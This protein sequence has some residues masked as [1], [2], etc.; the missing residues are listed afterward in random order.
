MDKVFLDKTGNNYF[1]YVKFAENIH[2]EINKIRTDPKSYAV[3]LSKLM[4]NYDH[5][6]K[7]LILGKSELEISEGY[8]ALE[9]AYQ[10]LM[11]KESSHALNFKNGLQKSAE[12]LVSLLVVNEGIENGNSYIF[13]NIDSRLNKYGVPIG[14]LHEIID[15]GSW[16]PKFVV[17]NFIICDKDLERKEREIIFSSN[18]KSFGVYSNILPS[19]SIVTVLNFSG[20]YFEKGDKVPKSVYYKYEHL[21]KRKLTYGNCDIARNI[22]DE[23]NQIKQ[24]Y[25]QQNDIQE[26]QDNQE[27]LNQEYYNTLQNNFEDMCVEQQNTQII[28][29]AFIPNYQYYQPQQQNVYDNKQPFISIN[30][31]P[32][33]TN[34]QMNQMTQNTVKTN[35]SSNTQLTKINNISQE[36]RYSQYPNFSKL[37][38]II[39]NDGSKT[40]TTVCQEVKIKETDKSP[41]NKSVLNYKDITSPK[42]LNY[43]S[44]SKSPKS[45]YNIIS[46]EDKFW[47]VLKKKPVR[48]APT[49]RRDINK[50]HIKNPFNN[51][52]LPIGS[53]KNTQ[54]ETEIKET[55]ERERLEEAINRK[56]DV[57]M[58]LRQTDLNKTKKEIISEP[59]KSNTNTMNQSQLNQST[60]KQSTIKQNTHKQN[61]QKQQP[62][63]IIE[64]NKFN[65]ETLDYLKFIRSKAELLKPFQLDLHINTTLQKIIKTH[66]KTILEDSQDRERSINILSIDNKEGYIQEIQLLESLSLLNSDDIRLDLIS[67]NYNILEN[68]EEIIKEIQ[69]I[70][71]KYSLLSNI[72]INIIKKDFNSLLTNQE[73]NKY[74]LLILNRCFDRLNNLE[75]SFEIVFKKMFELLRSKSSELVVFSYEMNS[76]LHLR[77]LFNNSEND[78]Y[79][80]EEI[81][82][83]LVKNEN[84]D[85][86]KDFLIG[87]KQYDSL[88]DVT[89]CCDKIDKEGVF[90]MNQFTN[91][92]LIKIN[93]I[94]QIS[95]M[96]KSVSKFENSQYFMYEQVTGFFFKK[97]EIAEEMNDTDELNE[98][99]LPEGV[100]RLTIFE[101]PYENYTYLK[102]NFVYSDG[103]RE[104]IELN[105]VK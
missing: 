3:F 12:D 35:K 67:I 53:V 61:N 101:K 10:Y 41:M 42:K 20:D 75:F 15:Y 102:K 103:I 64:N 105:K 37:D 99:F 59:Q 57:I 6:T 13:N 48:E 65:L 29:Q 95:N 56:H 93:E 31:N 30:N 100:E 22:S 74:D 17:L 78:S 68:D 55:E 44:K 62:Q 58:K 33:L 5:K 19:A 1:S 80:G 43:K 89:Q 54:N 94:L 86:N 47:T 36:K 46:Y 63:E 72:H 2:L 49:T 50:K 87:I 104:I 9:E 23:R 90:L 88:L 7:C 76:R 45:K 97:K 92:K 39:N 73:N 52:Y 14:E 40:L 28:N 85:F 11:Q 98:W 27:Q 82:K 70:A 32:S 84:F 51:N 66:I 38:T 4:K 96:I 79:S 25:D 81:Y 60:I 69:V 71:N 34:N 24:Q 91:Q 83:K 77:K 26:Y 21:F 8:E 18:V 16:N